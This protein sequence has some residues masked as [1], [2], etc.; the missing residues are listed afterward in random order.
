MFWVMLSKICIKHIQYCKCIA[1]VVHSQ[2]TMKGCCSN[3]AHVYSKECVRM[4]VQYIISVLLH[5]KV[6]ILCIVVFL[7]RH[8]ESSA[9]LTII[10]SQKWDLSSLSWSIQQDEWTALMYAAQHGQSNVAET[11]LQHGAN[12]DIQNVVSTQ[13][14]FFSCWSCSFSCWDITI[15]AAFPMQAK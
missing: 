11:L 1:V 4:N 6:Y 5:Q 3:C 9:V 2:D 13:S 15:W 14:H 10:V 12:V 7:S 8:D